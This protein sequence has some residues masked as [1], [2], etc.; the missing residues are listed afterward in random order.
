MREREDGVRNLLPGHKANR[1]ID[2]RVLDEALES[3][4]AVQPVHD[5]AQG[6]EGKIGDHEP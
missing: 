2:T 4:P 3:I 6:V 1:P 5:H